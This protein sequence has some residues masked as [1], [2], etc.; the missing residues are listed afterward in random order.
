MKQFKQSLSLER[1]RQITSADVSGSPDI[2][3]DS[4]SEPAD[5]T[6]SSIIFW[7]QEKYFDAVSASLAG[8]IITTAEG[9]KRLPGRHIL[10]TDKPY[11]TLLKLVSYWLRICSTQIQH[12]I[13]S[14]AVIDPAAKIGSP[15]SIGENC[16]IGKDCV[17]GDGCR[18]SANC[19]ISDGSV[20]GENCLLYPNVT[21]YEDSVIG[22]E[23]IIHSGAV[24][25]ADGFG[26]LL[27][28]GI[29]Q[30]I[31]QIG[32]VVIG[33]RV[34]IGAN[35]CVDRATLGSTIIG[36]GTKLDNMVHIAHN[37]VIGRHCMLCAQVGLAGSTKLGDYV[38][39]AGQVGVAGHLKIG[40][41]AMVGAQS[42]ITHEIPADSKYFGSPALEAITM[43]RILASQKNLP[44]IYRFYLKHNKSNT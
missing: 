23:V 18:I 2:V 15:V 43:K 16:V 27:M 8:L 24:I 37:C 30:K 6:A 22:S 36:E 26:F 21:I 29:Q 31:P 1:V 4:V 39:L 38:Y 40:D 12:E 7:E 34:E 42:G 32:N 33:D 19:I 35:S 9:A 3:L 11:F 25:G 44:D 28:E 10:I 17:I 41:R 5:A 13:K 20:L 14:S